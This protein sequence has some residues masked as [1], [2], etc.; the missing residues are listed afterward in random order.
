M[1]SVLYVTTTF[2][3]MAAFIEN[4]VLRLHARGVDVRVATLRPAGREYQPE[5]APLLPLVTSVGSPLA[6]AGWLALLRWLVRRPHVLVPE[7]ARVLWASRTSPYALA[8]HLGYLPAAARVA[9][10]AETNGSERIHGAWAHFPA[11]AAY[12]AARL[13]GR[14]FSMAAHAG[15]D[16]Y[17]SQA[18]LAHKARAADF[19]TAC[20]RANARMLRAL[21][22]GA[23]VE[24]LYHGTDLA[25]FGGVRRARATEPLLLVVGR[26]SPAKGFD[27]AVSALGELRRRGLAPR[28]VIVGEGP[29]RATLEALAAGLGVGAQL[30]FRGTL[31]HEELL[32]LYARAWLLLAPSKVVANG[33]RDGIPNV[34]IEAMAAG[35][36]VVGTSA[37][38][39]D[40]AVRPGVSGA[41]ARP[42]DPTSLADALEPLIRDPAAVDR[43]SPLARA[44][45]RERFDA[46][47]SFARLLE[48]FGGSPARVEEPA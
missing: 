22:P 2:P 42:G 13:T 21:A 10:L 24:W 48:L 9:D 37:T 11:T 28:L 25:R 41:L 35:L 40:E 12:L 14:R 47:A 38:G 5:Y 17:R 19:V 45:A 3:T 30:E 46:D 1:K 44:A 31:T 23:R 8:G 4:E 26:L 34:V 7:L 39:I 6:P 29:E 15:A 16:L 32:P 27:D 43:M 36:P 18:F 33:R 20:V